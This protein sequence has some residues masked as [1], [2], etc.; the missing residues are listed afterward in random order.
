MAWLRTDLTGLPTRAATSCSWKLFCGCIHRQPQHHRDQLV[1]IIMRRLN[2]QG[3]RGVSAIS[4][5]SNAT[6]QTLRFRLKHWRDFSIW[7]RD[8]PPFPIPDQ[9]NV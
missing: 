2:R 8:L 6:N 7:H 9:N 3:S 1:A 4:A 5:N